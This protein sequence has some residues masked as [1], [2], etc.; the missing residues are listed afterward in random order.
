MNQINFIKTT[1]LNAIITLIALAMPTV[2][3]AETVV[4]TGD[5]VTIGVNQTV[6]NNLYTFAGAVSLSGEVKGDVYAVGG[7]VT[8]NGPVAKDLTV[9]GGT[10]QAHSKIGDDLRVLAGDVVVAD[11]VGGDIFVIG[12]QVKILSSAKVKGNVYVYGGQAE[13]DG[14]ITGEVMGSADSVVVKGVVGGVDMSA[15]KLVLAD[16]ANIKG[17]L[18]LQSD[19]EVE[20]SIDATVGGNINR[21]EV[22]EKN[23]TNHNNTPIVFLASWFFT[24]LCALLFF[25]VPLENLFNTVKNKSALSGVIGFG[26]LVVAPVVSVVLLVTVLGLWLGVASLIVLMSVLVV[27]AVALPLLIGCYAL[28]LYRKKI[29]IDLWSAL[30]GILIIFIVMYIPVLGILAILAALVTV[31]GAVVYQIYKQ[32]R[33]IL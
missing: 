29:K 27:S 18:V 19:N 28:S 15:R 4:R 26:Y 21:S 5:S 9:I 12:G 6:E 20:R 11:Q 14:E 32:I 33:K 31:V 16:Q 10:V 13:I 30:A 2:A 7:T 8:V 24:S 17:D 23:I 1:F 22:V 3:L 25:R